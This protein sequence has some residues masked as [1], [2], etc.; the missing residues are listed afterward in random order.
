MPAMCSAVTHANL[1]GVSAAAIVGK[2]LNGVGATAAPAVIPQSDG[3][4][5]AISARAHPETIV[6]IFAAHFPGVCK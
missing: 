4:L 1:N 6:E 3:R 5:G 2:A